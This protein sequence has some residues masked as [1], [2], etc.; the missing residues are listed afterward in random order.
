MKTLRYAIALAITGLGIVPSLFAADSSASGGFHA[1][2]PG[3]TMNIEF[4]A[5]TTDA[6]GSGDGNMTFSG[7]GELPNTGEDNGQTGSI[8]DLKLKIDF[9][10]VRIDQ[11]RAAMSGLVRDANVNGYVGRRIILAVEDGGEGSKADNDKFTWGVYNTSRPNW[12]PSDSELKFD[13]GWTRTWIATDAERPDDRGILITRDS[14]E[15]QADCRSFALA[16][17]SLIDLPQGSGNIQVKP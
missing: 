12:L 14:R 1:V 2:S 10:C 9:D 5:R 16:A 8:A 7:P 15:S 6:N 13:D 3:G 11:N 17:Y 4:N